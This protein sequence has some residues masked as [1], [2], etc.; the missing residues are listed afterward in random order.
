MH[1]TRSA[2]LAGKGILESF[3]VSCQLAES[4][5]EESCAMHIYKCVDLLQDAEQLHNYG[6]KRINW[7]TEV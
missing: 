3:C 5:S 4:F 2:G 7:E 6:V 1:P